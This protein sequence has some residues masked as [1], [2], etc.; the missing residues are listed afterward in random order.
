MIDSYIYLRQGGPRPG[1]QLAGQ[2]VA[3]SFSR[4]LATFS[5]LAVT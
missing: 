4:S 1:S 2:I 5:P 3:E